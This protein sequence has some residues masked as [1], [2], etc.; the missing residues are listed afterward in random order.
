MYVLAGA[1]AAGFAAAAA[2]CLCTGCTAAAAPGVSEGGG[3]APTEKLRAAGGASAGCARTE[4][5][6]PPGAAACRPPP[7]HEP[8]QDRDKG[9]LGPG[10]P[11]HFHQAQARQRL[12]FQVITFPTCQSR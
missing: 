10:A 2:A 9:T 8:R 6:F 4:L 1:S 5:S 11:G 3:R 12:H 7:A